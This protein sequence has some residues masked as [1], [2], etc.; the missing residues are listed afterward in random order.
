MRLFRQK[1]CGDWSGV[2]DEMEAALK[3]LFQSR[4]TC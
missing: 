1:A 3:D 4:E 2:F